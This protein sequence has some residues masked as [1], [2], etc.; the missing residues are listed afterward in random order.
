[1]NRRRKPFAHPRQPMTPHLFTIL[2][3]LFGFTV[4]IAP[5]IA[6]PLQ[7]GKHEVG[8]WGSPN[9]LLVI[10]L[11]QMADDWKRYSGDPKPAWGVFA[12]DDLLYIEG[13]DD[14]AENHWYEGSANGMNE[15]HQRTGEV[16]QEP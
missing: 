11:D 8:V 3:A 10:T 5:A 14:N 13:R 15:A 7:T 2:Y 16:I 9:L 1:M 4:V 6:A 12:E